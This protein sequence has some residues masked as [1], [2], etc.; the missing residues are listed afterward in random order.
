ME[1][2]S[3]VTQLVC[4]CIVCEVLKKG[5]VSYDFTK[6]KDIIKAGRPKP[7][8]ENAYSEVYNLCHLVLTFPASTSSVERSFSSLKRIKTHSRN[9]HSQERLQY[10]V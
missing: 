7:G 3:I 8:L 1:C 10:L 2:Q 5:L 4:S 6:K 9:S